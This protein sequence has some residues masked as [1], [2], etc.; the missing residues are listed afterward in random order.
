MNLATQL[1]SLFAELKTV[2]QEILQHLHA[3]LQQLSAKRMSHIIHVSMSK[4]L[5]SNV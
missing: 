3:L 4:I 5:F 2:E 1:T